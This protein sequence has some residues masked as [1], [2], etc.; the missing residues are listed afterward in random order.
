MFHKN[1]RRCI[2]KIMS[3]PEEIARFGVALVKKTRI[4][5]AV[6]GMLI[7]LFIVLGGGILGFYLTKESFFLIIA[8]FPVA[9]VS[10]MIFLM[11]IFRPNMLQ[12]EEHEQRMFQLGAGM[13]QKGTEIPENKVDEL[14]SMTELDTKGIEPS[15]EGSDE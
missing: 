14:P 10:L 1:H 13:G 6:G 9:F 8:A 5:S 15:R 2:L 11:F 3:F 7:F 12:S 4:N